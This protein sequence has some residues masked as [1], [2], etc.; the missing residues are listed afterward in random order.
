MTDPLAHHRQYLL[1]GVMNFFMEQGKVALVASQDAAT[2]TWFEGELARLAPIHLGSEIIH[3]HVQTDEDALQTFNA[4]LARITLQQATQAGGQAQA[5]YLLWVSENEHFTPERFHVLKNIILQFSG[6]QLKL[7]VSVTS[8]RWSER[9]FDIAGRKIAYWFIPASTPQP[10]LAAPATAASLPAAQT[11]DAQAGPTASDKPTAD[12]SQAAASSQVQPNPPAR[13]LNLLVPAIGVLVVLS[14]AAYWLN[15]SAK[16]SDPAQRTK[17]STQAKNTQPGGHGEDKTEAA[18]SPT[19]KPD[20]AS[21]AVT[22][23]PETDVQRTTAAADTAAS[24]TA[25]SPANKNALPADAKSAVVEPGPT[26]A[27]SSAA[28]AS[29]SA[30][31]SASGPATV[32]SPA[33]ASAASAAAV[34]TPVLAAPRAAQ[35]MTINTQADC[36]TGAQNPATAKPISYNKETDYIYIK[37]AQSRKICVAAAGSAYSLVNVNVIN[38]TRIYGKSPW[39]VYSPDLRQVELYFQ[40]ARV[41]LAPSITDH[42][43]VVPY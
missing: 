29:S 19:T 8:D 10:E 18:D 25:A 43:Q 36:P 3:L 27:R 15:D 39:R 1:Q 22:V 20:A 33:P 11:R 26:P 40:G 6:L 38:G 12:T 28:L 14:A 16:S 24:D 23:P 21:T 17:E 7:F 34:S 42:V 9:L 31:A 2:Q 32:A 37:S 30:S 5:N 41:V 4:L 35:A 13:K